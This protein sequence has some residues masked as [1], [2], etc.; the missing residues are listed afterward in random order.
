MEKKNKMAG[1]IYKMVEYIK[2]NDVEF[3][4]Y[5]ALGISFSLYII[6]TK[7]WG[8][9]IDGITFIIP[10]ILPSFMVINIISIK[11]L[12]KEKKSIKNTIYKLILQIFFFI[13]IPLVVSNL[14]GC[15]VIWVFGSIWA[16]L[17]LL[18]IYTDIKHKWWG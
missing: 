2:K 8:S 18:L 1:Y 17:R 11:Q 6:I 12:L 14:A 13:A 15:I 5:T 16:L 10:F 3:I 4:I 9:Y 7:G